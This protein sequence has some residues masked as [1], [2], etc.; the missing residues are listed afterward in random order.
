MGI[1]FYMNMQFS[2]EGLIERKKILKLSG[3]MELDYGLNAIKNTKQYIVL[4]YL[5]TQQ[6]I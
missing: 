3:S 4:Y 5:Y 6:I 2:N 1:P